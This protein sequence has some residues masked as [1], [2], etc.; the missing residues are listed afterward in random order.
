MPSSDEVEHLFFERN[1][2]HWL[3][4]LDHHEFIKAIAAYTATPSHPLR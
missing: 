2:S 4:M 1:A 3:R